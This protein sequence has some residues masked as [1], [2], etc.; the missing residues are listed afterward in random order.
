MLPL[1]FICLE[2]NTL[3]MAGEKR[4]QAQDGLCTTEAVNYNQTLK[5]GQQ[6]GTFTEENSANTM[7]ACIKSC[8]LRKRCEVAFMLKESCFLVRCHNKSSCQPRKEKSFSFNPRLAYVFRHAQR[9]RNA[10]HS[11]MFSSLSYH[12]IDNS[13]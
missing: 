10:N 13:N 12:Y 1:L 5:F 4:D 8:C 2:Q 7:E 9:G 3:V 11:L 6:A